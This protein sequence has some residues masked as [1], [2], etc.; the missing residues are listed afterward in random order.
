MMIFENR[1][2]TTPQKI[3]RKYSTLETHYSTWHTC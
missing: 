1:V 2:M 3:V